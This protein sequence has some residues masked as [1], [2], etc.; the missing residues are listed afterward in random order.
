MASISK[1]VNITVSLL[2]ASIKEAGFGIPLV[3]DYHTRFSERIRFYGGQ[4]EMISDGFVVSDPAYIAAGQ[5]FAQSPAPEEIAIGRKA[6]MPTLSIKLTPTAINSKLY[7]VKVTSP[8]GVVTTVS[9]TSD[10]TATVAEIVT[11]LVAVI[12][13]LAG[14][15]A[16][17]TGA[18]GTSIT[19][20]AETPGQWFAVEVVEDGV[21]AG[22]AGLLVENLTPDAGIAADAA[23]IKNVDDTW[24][25][26]MSTSQ[27]KAEL[28]A[29]AAWVESNGKLMVQASQDGTI[30]DGT[31]GNVMLLSQTAA[32][33]R[34]GFIYH[35]NPAQF[36][37]LAWMSNVFPI[38]PGGV[39][40][41]FR[42]LA[43][44]D[45]SPLSTTQMTNIENANGS[46]FVDIGG[47]GMTYGKDG[48]GKVA[49][50]EWLDI[51]RDTDWYD[52]QI[53]V[54]I[55]KVMLGNNKVPMTND[56]I[57][58]VEAGLRAATTRA[59][60]S[61]FLDP[62]NTVYTIPDISEISANN[63]ARRILDKLKVQ[64]RV[65]GAINSTNV[66]ATITA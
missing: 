43:N 12:N 31:A 46:Y 55:L 26:I 4:D 59:E 10:G 6:N 37:G 25:G 27:G 11:G 28:D 65:Q 14:V 22:H 57:A 13:P 7:S 56:G 42:R 5:A 41:T 53:G 30:L 19:V 49:S 16:V 63:R 51:I 66:V 24:Y 40:F 52:V 48:G 50:G 21:A 39:T 34:T 35:Q 2:T 23:A 62:A 64:G 8:A 61:G 38:D 58:M 33:R 29:L 18:L 15:A 20:T 60:D 1:V 32:R 54:E 17:D 9:F 45:K 44:V 47:V 3:M 36:A